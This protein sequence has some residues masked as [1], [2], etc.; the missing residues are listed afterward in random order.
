[1]NSEAQHSGSA[2]RFALTPVQQAY[3]LGQEEGPLGG[4]ACHMYFEF[5]GTRL[6]TERLAAAVEQVQQHHAL[7]RARFD[8]LDQARVGARAPAGLRPE[9][10]PLEQVREEMAASHPVM[11]GGGGL[12]VRVSELPDGGSRL[13]VGLALIAA[14]PPSI[15]TVLRDLAAAYRRETLTDPAE[16]DFSAFA[17][18]RAAASGAHEAPEQL[19]NPPKL[20]SSA[21]ADHVVGARFVRHPVP[22][23]AQVME[24]LDRRAAREDVAVTDL[25]FA[26]FAH[27]VDRWSEVDD[28]VLN[29]PDF[30]RPAGAEGVVGDFSTLRAV[31]VPLSRAD[32][33]REVV[34][35]A[36]AA[37]R[38]E[39]PT[40][41]DLVSWARERGQDLRTLGVVYTRVGAPWAPA[42]CTETFGPMSWMISQTPQ[43]HLDCLVAPAYEGGPPEM[44]WDVVEE[45]LPAPVV[46]AMAGYCAATLTALADGDW[47]LPAD[48]PLP[49]DQRRARADVNATEAETSDLLL[50]EAVLRHAAHEGDRPA[51]FSDRVR[52]NRTQLADAALRTA[53]LL[54]DRGLSA[55]DPVGVCLS[56]GVDQVQAVLGVLAA[57]GCYVPISPEQPTERRKNVLKRAGARFVLCDR[58]LAEESEGE[59][60]AQDVAQSSPAPDVPADAPLFYLPLALADRAAPLSEPV[61]VS[62]RCPAY[63]IFTSGS[64]GQPKGVEVSHRSA[65]NS[66]LDLNRRWDVGAADRCLPI[67][68]LDFDLSVY[69][70]FGPLVAGGSV[71]IAAPEQRR[72]PAQWIRLMNEHRVTVWD[73]VPVLLDVLLTQAEES[74]GP[75]SL[76]LVMTGGDWVPVDLPGRLH[77]LLPQAR[78]VA[79]GGATEG[80][81]YSNFYEVEAVDEDRASIP[82]GYPL[83]NQR[84]RVVDS[85]GRD[86]PDL[87]PGELWIGGAGVATGYRND[88]ERTR[89][90]FV[91]VHGHRWYRTGDLG[92]YL[93]G[94]V[95]EFLGR[96]DH[97]VKVNGYRIEL[98]E[99]ESVLGRHD[100]VA[101]AVA[102]VAGETSARRIVTYLQPESGKIDTDAVRR[103]AT[104]WLPEYAVPEEYLL[105]PDFPLN[106]NGKIDRRKLASWT[107]PDVAAVTEEPVREGTESAIAAIWSDLLG[108]EV[109]ARNVDFD[110]MGGNSLLSMR[111]TQRLSKIADTSFTL[112]Q[113]Q[114]ATTIADLAHLVRTTGAQA[115]EHTS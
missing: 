8:D 72:D 86:C 100:A 103:H 110:R 24:R 99:I 96:I 54:V 85:A 95:M 22:L 104:Q 48:L 63:I 13:H 81:I 102:L 88:E 31:Q 98:G 80:S 34:S 76:R 105:L 52:W 45:M 15:H 87:V 9:N 50:H 38:S 93:P 51:L 18:S 3:R 83:A 111:L 114:K 41:H 106:Q 17:A 74:S 21:S 49:D 61:R 73:S 35:R 69:E 101:R 40:V 27:T 56:D 70:I 32:S 67:S 53:S 108:Q 6:D 37:L 66:I 23:D 58:E 19:P 46:E 59:R 2:E 79:C 109:R 97:Q 7:L 5:D 39:A 25:L 43:V 107:T 11:D 57:G 89:E 16:F 75:E 115:K 77:A 55:G 91:T 30:T 94:A 28:F 84:Y 47:D 14:D 82:Y 26:A 65:M 36:A 90:R 71:V 113:V 60:Y 4:V 29:V 64:T 12:D 112:R 20:P 44:A 68:A 42:S 33:L 78:F 1:M 62:P 92:R 10:R